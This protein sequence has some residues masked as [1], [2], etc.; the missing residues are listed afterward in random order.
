M[1]VQLWDVATGK[2]FAS[3]LEHPAPVASAAFSPDGTRV[4]A[5]SGM[6]A[7]LWDAVTGK[8]L[9]SPLEHQA[10]V[11][12]A[13]FSP[14]ARAW[15][16]RAMTTHGRMGWWSQMCCSWS[17]SET[18]NTGEHKLARTGPRDATRGGVVHGSLCSAVAAAM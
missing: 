17:G 16:P 4:I 2:I 3:P 5:A 13:A 7:Y 6:T 15:S 14:M 10:A 12:H 9:P 11:M 1:T 18:E 8:P